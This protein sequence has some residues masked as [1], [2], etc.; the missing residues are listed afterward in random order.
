MAKNAL[1]FLDPSDS[2]VNCTCNILDKDL[3][4]FQYV[5]YMFDRTNQM[6]R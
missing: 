5:Q 3:G 6:F 4:T 1:R 2:S